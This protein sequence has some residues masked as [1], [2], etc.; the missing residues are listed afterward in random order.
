MALVVLL[1]AG[2]GPSA[3][4]HLPRA[5]AHAAARDHH[6]PGPSARSDTPTSLVA[7]GDGYHQSA[8]A[9]AAC[10]LLSPAQIAVQ[11]GGTVSPGVAVDPYCQWLIGD[12]AF[13]A[14]AVLPGVPLAEATGYVTTLASTSGIGTGSE[15][16]NN[17][18]LYFSDGPDSFWLLYQAV[19]DFTALHTPQLEALAADVLAHGLP[20][21]D[22]PATPAPSGPPVYFAGDSTAAGPEWAWAT[23]HA[24]TPALATLSEYQVGTGLLVPGFFDWSSHLAAMV[25]ARH[26]KVVVFMGSAN[27][28]QPVATGGTDAAVGSPAWDALYS[29]RVST[30][31]RD[32]TAEGAK[33]LWVGEPAMQDPTLSAGMAVIDALYAQQAA[34]HPGVTYFDP[35]PV[36]NGPGG[37]YTD[38]LTVN[39]QPTEVRLD[40]IHLNAAGS[41]VLADALA[42]AV[43]R[44]LAPPPA[45]A[46]PARPTPRR[47]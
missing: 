21:A 36:L 25:A 46:H 5:V 1:V 38:T 23:Y 26:P 13:V 45:P 19:G 20:P 16:A 6:R 41:E 35:G 33:V 12:D 31:M 18:Y 10:T 43:A 14:L 2:G 47:P 15:Q 37:A 29:Q 30:V 8:A 9:R 42:P 39:G 3:A 17:R 32:L 4:G 22:G 40:G 7:F 11:F 28:A 44:L 34:R 24:A 27:D